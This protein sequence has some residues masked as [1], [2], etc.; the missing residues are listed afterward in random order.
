MPYTPHTEEEIRE[1]LR[2]IGEDDLQNLFKTIPE[3]AILNAPLNLPPPVSEKELVDHL[4]GLSRETASVEDYTSFL[5]G[6]SYNHY[7]P[8]VVKHII[9]RSEFYSAYTPYQP[10]ISQGTLQAIFEFQTLICQLTGMEVA[11]ASMYDGASAAA[12]AILMAKR[13]NKR[14]KVLLSSALHPEYREVIRTYLSTE[15]DNTREVLYCTEKGQT[16]PEAVEGIIDKET[17]ALVVQ[18]PNFFG[19]LE[20]IK[21][22]GELA[23]KSGALLIVV[24]TEP[25]SLAILKPPGKLMADIVV[26][27]AQSFGIPPSFGGP[28][29]GFFAT[30]ERYV[31]QMPGRV[32]GETLDN[33]GSKGYV[34]TLSTREQH[35]RRERSTSNICTNEALCALASTVYLSLLGKKGLREL[36]MVNLSKANYAKESLQGVKCVRQLFTAPTFNE[37]VVDLTVD[38]EGLFT[39]LKGKGVLGGIPLLRHYPNH[40]RS[41]LITVTEAN[42]KEDIDRLVREIETYGRMSR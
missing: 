33:K 15:A 6:G 14:P 10:E 38:P 21:S 3:E 41:I 32:V 8:S 16:L 18:H 27:D 25:L 42:S 5:G 12:E 40:K 1:M 17:S 24:I 7:I 11:N 30:L 26:G 29:L 39:Y 2:L 28:S 34:L 20:D 35:I 23:H 9:S 4:T 22:L 13:I 31:R 36:A 19:C 37:F